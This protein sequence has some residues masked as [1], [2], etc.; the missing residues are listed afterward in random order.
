MKP[1][2]QVLV[3]DDDQFCIDN[4]RNSFKNYNSFDFLGGENTLITAEKRLFEV[5]PDLIFLDVEF[6]EGSGIEFL[7]QL[8][9]K[10]NWNLEV[11]FYTSHDK[12]LLNALRESA[13][14]YLLKPYAEEDLNAI[15]ERF[16]VK[17]SNQLY[18]SKIEEAISK[19][20]PEN[21]SFLLPTLTGYHL[22]RINQVGFFLY[23]KNLKGW[24]VFLSDGKSFPLK[25]SRNSESLLAFSSSFI[26]IN[27]NCIINIDYLWN[28][29]D[30]KCVLLP[31]FDQYSNL[32]ISRN[33]HKDIL[34]KFYML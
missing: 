3:F 20:L 17:M 10:I 22:L 26:Q 6:P 16:L 29:K 9:D 24:T 31:P 14:D 7:S 30:K 2:F 32:I 11:V 23:D 13:F 15:V 12:Y 21:K 25:R 19:L 5:K 18:K 33:Y 1:T 34:N 27:Q 28:I 8:K 4:L